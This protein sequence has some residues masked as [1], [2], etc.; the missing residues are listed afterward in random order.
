MCICVFNY[1]FYLICSDEI[2]LA[3]LLQ[4]NLGLCNLTTCLLPPLLFHPLAKYFCCLN[5]SSNNFVCTES[6][7]CGWQIRFWMLQELVGHNLPCLRPTVTDPH[8]V[9]TV[10]FQHA[11]SLLA[12]EVFIYQEIIKKKEHNPCAL[13]RADAKL[14]CGSSPLSELSWDGLTPGL[15]DVSQQSMSNKLMWT[16][17]RKKWEAGCLSYSYQVLGC[18]NECCDNDSQWE[19]CCHPHSTASYLQ[20]YPQG[21]KCDTSATENIYGRYV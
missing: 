6:R 20:P 14:T 21:Y 7:N 18:S 11:Q 13:K 10:P 5:V 17:V 12:C 16:K 15:R 3:H 1:N 2:H 9:E 19:M 4:N 8:A